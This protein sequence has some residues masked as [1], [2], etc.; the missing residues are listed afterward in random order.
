MVWKKDPSAHSVPARLFHGFF[1]VRNHPRSWKNFTWGSHQQK[2]VGPC[3]V[4]SKNIHKYLD[5]LKTYQ[6]LPTFGQIDQ[7]QSRY[8][9]NETVVS[10]NAETFWDSVDLAGSFHLRNA[11]DW[12]KWCL[13]SSQISTDSESWK[14]MLPLITWDSYFFCSSPL[15]LKEW[16]ISRVSEFQFHRS[17]SCFFHISLL[18]NHLSAWKNSA[19]PWNLDA[20]AGPSAPKESN[21]LVQSRNSLREGRNLIHLTLMLGWMTFFGRNVVLVKC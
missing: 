15:E 17:F 19:T 20:K 21:C 7:K 12:Q 11:P 18:L 13:V 14:K 4:W 1:I 10:Q 8:C 2:N 16:N 3:E 9:S 6:L 5:S